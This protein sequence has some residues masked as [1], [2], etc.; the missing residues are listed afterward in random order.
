MWSPRQRGNCARRAAQP[1]FGQRLGTIPR[2]VV[3]SSLLFVLTLT[4]TANAEKGI[5]ILNV[6]D[7]KDV[8]I[9]GVEIGPEGDG[10]TGRTDGKGKAR[11]KL[12]PQTQPG[13]RVTLRVFSSPAQRDLV[14]ISPW[15]R[16]AQVPPFE[17]E[18]NNYL[19][20]I[21]ADRADRDLLRTPE[22]LRAIASNIN[23]ANSSQTPSGTAAPSET[24]EER[25]QR[26]LNEVAR[27]YGFSA[28]DVDA[29]IREW[30]KKTRDP[31]D[32][33]LAA[34]YERDYPAATKQLSDSF[35]IRRREEARVQAQAAQATRATADAAYFLGESLHAQGRYACPPRG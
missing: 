24:A 4:A 20:I 29:A 33:G 17:N 14:F 32:A 3:P 15:D 5:L 1:H 16:T 35:E 18:S 11:I 10:S 9:A 28:S 26:A 34:L 31:Y 8:V 2:G 23:R 19:P 22:A 21:L 30:G 13:H 6:T 25:R 27:N 12:A 7:T